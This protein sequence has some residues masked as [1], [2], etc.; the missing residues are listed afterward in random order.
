[1]RRLYVDEAAVM[2]TMLVRMA[3]GA[4]YPSHRHAAAEECFVLSGDKAWGR[5]VGV[6]AAKDGALIVTEDGSGTIW[7]VTYDG[8]A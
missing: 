7:R 6:A 5:P 2:V 8:P 3:P 4:R 1:M